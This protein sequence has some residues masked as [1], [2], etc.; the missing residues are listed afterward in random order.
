MFSWFSGL[1]RLLQLKRSIPQGMAPVSGGVVR[2]PGGGRSVVLP[3]VMDLHPVTNRDYLRY[4]QARNQRTPQWMH[5]RGFDDPDQP[6]V[7]I[8]FK[9]AR[10]YARWAGKRLPTEAEWIRAARA[11]ENRPYPWGDA[12]PQHG[13]AWVDAGPNGAPAPVSN[14]EE[15]RGGAGPFGHRDLIGNVWEWIACGR[16]KGGFWGRGGFNIDARLDDKRERV[17][18]GYGFRCAS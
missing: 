11:H 8:T 7:G 16:L 18:A 4:I 3:F 10:G 1:L 12:T 5:R 6:V 15:R 9:E 17:S 14:P 13:L 2:L